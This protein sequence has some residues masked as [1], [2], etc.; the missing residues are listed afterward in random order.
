M[1]LEINSQRQLRFIGEKNTSKKGFFIG[2]LSMDQ[3]VKLLSVLRYSQLDLI[4]CSAAKNIDLS[5]YSLEIHY[6]GK[7]RSFYTCMLPFLL[8]DL[9]DF[10]LTL[11]DKV[12][13]IETKDKF[14]IKFDP[15]LK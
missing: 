8:D 4:E 13:L 7:M 14:E 10:L 2:E 12:Y 6:N 15:V 5:T 1:S 9:K 3:Y 11:P